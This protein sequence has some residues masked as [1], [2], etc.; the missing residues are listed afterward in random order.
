M[1]WNGAGYPKNRFSMLNVLNDPSRDPIILLRVAKETMPM[2]IDSAKNYAQI[3]AAALALTVVFREKILGESGKVKTNW[4][5]FSTWFCFLLTIG[6]SVIYQ[7]VA[8]RWLEYRIEATLGINDWRFPINHFL[9]QP[10]IIYGE[11]IFMFIAAAVLLF[12]TSARQL[13]TL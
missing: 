3:S 11:M 1:P 2:Y 8:V 12:L 7:W 6:L 9:L 13:R 4:L 5:L 10:G